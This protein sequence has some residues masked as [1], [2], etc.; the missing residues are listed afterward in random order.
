MDLLSGMLPTRL[1][2]RLPKSLDLISLPATV[3]LAA[4][5]EAAEAR[6]LGFPLF[7]LDF[8]NGLL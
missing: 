6:W 1:T 3:L 5:H 7:P 2:T 8:Y 4:Q